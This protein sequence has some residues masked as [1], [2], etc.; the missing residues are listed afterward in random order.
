MPTSEHPGE[1]IDEMYDTIEEIL[2]NEATRDNV[3]IMGD[4]N[5]VVGEGLDGKEVGQFGLGRRN[6]SYKELQG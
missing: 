5:S 1:E 4:W 2:E 3:I 6:E